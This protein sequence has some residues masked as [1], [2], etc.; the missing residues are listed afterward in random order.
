MTT[1]YKL[2]S[3]FDPLTNEPLKVCDHPGCSEEGL[4][5]A[6]QSPEALTVYYWFCLNRVRDYN[7][8]WNFYRNR[9]EQEI[10]LMNRADNTWQRPTWRFGMDMTQRSQNFRF[11][12]PHDIL[13]WGKYFCAFEQ[14]PVKPSYFAHDSE[15]GRALSILQIE[16][17]VTLETL[18]SHYFILVK[19][20]HPDANGG[21]T[22]SE[23]KLKTINHAYEILKKFL[24]A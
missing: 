4:Y 12:D 18:K 6:P 1:K 10:E 16:G 8:Q 17:P 20:Y 7:A 13:G 19:K 2:H 23:E 14:D 11:H 15:E 5:K 24:A 9:A 3:F 22:D 21:C